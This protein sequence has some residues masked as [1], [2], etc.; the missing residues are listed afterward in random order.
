MGQS[1][2]TTIVVPASTTNYTRGRNHEIDKI[3]IHHMAGKLTAAQC[4]SIF[5]RAGRG[6]SS[7]YG[8]GYDGSVGLYVLENS[9]SWASSSRSNDNRAI[10]IE[11]SNDQIG[12]EWHVG[13]VALN[14]LI[15][16]C[17]DICQRYNIKSLNYTNDTTG[18]L[19]RH[20]MFTATTCPGPYLQSKFPYIVEQVKARL[21][22]SQPT[23]APAPSQPQGNSNY[24]VVRGDTLS[25]IG[26]R[27]G[28]KWQDIAS[29]NGIVKPYTIYVGQKLRL[30]ASV[31]APEDKG[32]DV[33]AVAR[34][35]I[36][37]KYGNGDARVRNLTN[38][39]YSYS[40]VQNAV[41]EILSGKAPSN[42][43]QSAPVQSVPTQIVK[44]C[45]VKV[46]NAIDYNGRKLNSS[47][48]SRTYDVIEVR[49]D[50][51]VIGIGSAVTAAMKSSNLKRV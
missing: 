39:G 20:N 31:N 8:I 47:V 36:N 40:K 25:G 10:T 24:I 2:Y 6:G 17:V 38:A 23:P 45:K 43:T 37:G 44:G 33:Y 29:Y 18:N 27:L 5:A 21:G 3:T 41:N 13:D 34:D 12:G 15:D 1:K 35:V 11:V 7:N 50:R 9:R 49:G 19:T 42:N 48:L 30:P 14:K 28:I 32:Y 16:L 26:K 22:N 4:G 51:V 46:L